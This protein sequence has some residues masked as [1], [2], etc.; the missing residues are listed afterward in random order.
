[1]SLKYSRIYS[2]IKGAQWLNGRDNKNTRNKVY[3]TLAPNHLLVNKD[4]ALLAILD[5][6]IILNQLIKFEAPIYKSFLDIFFTNFQWLI[7][8][9][10][11][12]LKIHRVIY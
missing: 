8:Q 2:F 9:G 6:L 11:I 10:A 3:E 5:V 4:G 12:I 7:L 1:M